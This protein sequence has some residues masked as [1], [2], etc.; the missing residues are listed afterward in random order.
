MVDDILEV[1]QCDG[2]QDQGGGGG[3]DDNGSD[4]FRQ[5]YDN[6]DLL[7]HGDNEFGDSDDG[8][9][10]DADIEIEMYRERSKIVR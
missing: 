10:D 7:G 3:D 5:D 4:C 6:N 1:D 9:D 2:G 8:G